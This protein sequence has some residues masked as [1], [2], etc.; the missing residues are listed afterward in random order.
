MADVAGTIMLIF[1]YLLI[2]LYLG[3]KLTN[4]VI[5]TPAHNRPNYRL[6][7]GLPRR[8]KKVHNVVHESIK[9]LLK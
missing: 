9:Q 5:K 2:D 3:G 6:G 7:V 1:G 4:E 8:K